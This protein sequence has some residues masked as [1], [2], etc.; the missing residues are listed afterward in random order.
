MMKK[1]I[2]PNLDDLMNLNLPDDM[3]DTKSGA[4]S[5]SSASNSVPE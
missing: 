4:S 2:D 5:T 3:Q 1:P